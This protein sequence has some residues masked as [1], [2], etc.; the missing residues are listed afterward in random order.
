MDEQTTAC[1]RLLC[2]V[3]QLAVVDS[4]HKPIKIGESLRLDE[5]AQTALDFLFVHGDPFLEA[6]D[7]EPSTFR[8]SLLKKMFSE[9]RSVHYPDFKKRIFRANYRL[10]DDMRKYR[11]TGG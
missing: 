9:E 11:G 8:A 1:H 6:I 2:A 5:N 7:M 10:W 3:V 4:F